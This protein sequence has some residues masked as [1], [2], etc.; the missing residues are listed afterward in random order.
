MV[1]YHDY[2]LK[3]G[4]LLD[5]N[6]PWNRDSFHCID[7]VDDELHFLIGCPFYDGMRRKMFHKAQLCNRDFILFT[8]AIDFFVLYDST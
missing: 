2:I 3:L 8:N 4:V 1:N 7:S 6:S 5:L